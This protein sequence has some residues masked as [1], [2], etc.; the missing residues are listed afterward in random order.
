MDES[1]R[2]L[3]GLY[4]NPC[5]KRDGPIAATALVRRLI[6]ITRDVRDYEPMSVKLLN[7]WSAGSAEMLVHPREARRGEVVGGWW[8]PEKLR[9]SSSSARIEPLVNVMT[10]FPMLN[11]FRLTGAA[12]D[13]QKC[14]HVNAA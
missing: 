14:L 13:G 5:T 2:A 9:P 12:V 11:H 1:T 8:R 3:A 7:P 4:P 6:V 10:S